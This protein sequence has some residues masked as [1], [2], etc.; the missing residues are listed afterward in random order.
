[1]K[2]IFLNIIIILL[3]SLPK[4]ESQNSITPFDYPDFNFIN[5][6]ANKIFIPGDSSG[7]EKLFLKF[8]DLLIFGNKQIQ[9][10]QIGGSHIQADVY[11][12]KIREKLQTMVPGIKGARGF[13]FPYRI[14]KTNTPSNYWVEYTGIWTSC[15]NVEK[16]NNCNL[17]LSGISV[18]TFD[19]LVTIQIFSRNS[20]NYLNYDFNRVKLFQ[21]FGD[22]IYQAKI[23]NKSG[24]SIIGKKVDST[25]LLFDLGNFSD[26]LKLVIMKS[27]SIQKSYTLHGILLENDDPGIVYHS[28]G[29]N[30]ASVASFLKCSLFEQQLSVINPDLVI[31]SL[32]I[33]DAHGKNFNRQEF[34]RSY[35]SL[36][37]KIRSTTPG[38][39]IIFTTNND[40]YLTKK[41]Q[42]KNGELVQEAMF[43]LA[44]KF[45]GGV[46]DMYSIMGGANSILTWQKLNL[47]K[48]DKVHFTTEGYKILGELFYTAILNVYDFHLQKN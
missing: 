27:D 21:D 37:Q 8:D 5:Y 11:S 16:E 23:I 4:A 33:N 36:V 6:E 24:D 12:D 10:V 25:Y 40:S 44:K 14:A 39:P 15:R 29:I 43:S 38:V 34:E 32:G 31:L 3:G 9:I 1:M 13:V 2:K 46:W 47:A 48:K 42:N 28:I 7:F 45:N 26:T 22:N 20:G 18:T 17:G 30:G 35:A 19:T 41:L